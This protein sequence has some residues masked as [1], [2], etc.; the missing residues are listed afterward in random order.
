MREKNDTSRWCCLGSS[1]TARSNEEEKMSRTT[2]T[3]RSASWKTSAGA[4]VSATRFCKTS[5]NLNR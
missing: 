4:L 5:F 2:R 1:T 3:D